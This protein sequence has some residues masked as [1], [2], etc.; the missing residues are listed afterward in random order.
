MRAVLK[1]ALETF[2]QRIRQL[3]RHICG[4]SMIELVEPL[5]RYVLGWQ[6]YFGL[7]QIPRVWR[8]LDEWMRQRLREIQLK[9]WKRGTTAYRECI[10]PGAKPRLAHKVAANCR[11]WWFIS[12]RSLNGVLATAYFNRLGFPRLISST[13]RT[14]RC[15]PACR[16]VWQGAATLSCP[17]CRSLQ[18]LHPA[19]AQVLDVEVVVHAVV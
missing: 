11:R 13:T 9:H 18:S 8:E 6:A 16:V 7:A 12:S 17:L 4:R 5:R 15:G 3:T 1:K 19:D 14:A 2:K 10:A